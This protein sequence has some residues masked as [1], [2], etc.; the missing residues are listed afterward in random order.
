M[1]LAPFAA[2]LGLL[3][4][5][6]GPLPAAEA[7]IAAQLCGGGFVEIPL[8]RKAPPEPPCIAKACHSAACRKRIDL[9]Q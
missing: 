5:A 8:R 1:S 4:L 3:P 6:L 9:A 2:L 7:T